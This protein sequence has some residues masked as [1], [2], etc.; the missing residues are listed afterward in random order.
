MLNSLLYYVRAV[1]DLKNPT[2]VNTV[3]KVLPLYHFLSGFSIP[4]QP[5]Q[6]SLEREP[7]TLILAEL[8]AL[9]NDKSRYF[10]SYCT[11]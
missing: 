4:N 5:L 2:H 3:V 1:I 9:V 11:R 8:A 6:L 7:D 10:F